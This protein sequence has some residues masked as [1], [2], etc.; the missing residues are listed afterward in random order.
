[1]MSNIEIAENFDVLAKLMELYNED[2]FK[3]R[4]YQNA[5]RNIKSFEL[6]IAEMKPADISS[7]PGVGKAVAAKVSELLLTGSIQMLDEIVATTPA[8]IIE[9]M[10]IKGIGIKKI[11][12]IWKELHIDNTEDLLKACKE[13]LL[14]N[15]KGFGVKTQTKIQESIEFYLKNQN[16]VLLAAALNFTNQ[17]NQ[18]LTINFPDYTFLLTGDVYIQNNVIDKLQYVT[19]ADDEVLKKIITLFS[20]EKIDNNIFNFE[21]GIQIEFIKETDEKLIGKQF[22]LSCT[23]DFYNSFATQFSVSKNEEASIFSDSGLQYIPPCMRNNVKWIQKAKDNQLPEL[24]TTN[25]IKGII[26]CHSTWSDGAN[27]IEEIVNELRDNNFEY[28]VLSDHSKSAFYAEGLKEDRI[29]AQHKEIDNLNNKY[30]DFTIFKS[31][32]SDILNNGSLD[33]AE[34]VLQI[35]DLVIAS[36]HTNLGMNEEAATKR[37]ITAVENPYTNILGHMTGRLLLMR[38]GYPVNHKKIIDACAA[39]N[40]VIEINANPRRLDIDWRHIEY[41]LEKNVLL[42]INPDAHN[43]KGLYDIHYGVL[44]AQKAG[45]SKNSN[46]SSYNLTEFKVFIAQQQLKRQSSKK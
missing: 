22:Q 44:S 14:S 40:V 20:L 46:L 4:A 15:V 26:H 13:N 42:S 21:N 38:N 39:N 12:T 30:T 11:Q 6:P 3:I 10:Q 17:L 34:D 37:I 16:K 25:D 27:T 35:F 29:A 23:E 2:S 19:N 8:G 7:I 41:A 1:M 43:L 33:Y 28:L 9:M 36:V 31:I 24:I 18:S 5:T 45:L 32:E